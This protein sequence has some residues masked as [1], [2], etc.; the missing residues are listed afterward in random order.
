MNESVRRDKATVAYLR[1]ASR[2]PQDAEAI[3]H[4]RAGCERIAAKYGL[5]IVRE[6]RDI[7]RPAQLEQQH[8]MLRMLRDLGRNQD[9]AFVVIWDYSRLA[10]DLEQLQAII[11]WIEYCGAQVITITGV[12]AAARFVEERERAERE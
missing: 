8:G 6:Y 10:R 12:E 2:H 11:D 7:G 4:Q 1:I 5:T 3:N 9:V